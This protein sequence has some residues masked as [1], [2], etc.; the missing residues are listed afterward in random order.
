MIRT[1]A[2]RARR[3]L[4]GAALAALGTLT[5]AACGDDVEDPFVVE[6][7]GDISG[8]LYFDQGRDGFYE[9][10]EGDSALAG[11]PIV[12]RVRGTDQILASTTTDA[13]G[14]FR[15]EDIEV[16]TH[17]LVFDVD[18]D[19]AVV[20]LN[21]QPVSVRIAEVTSVAVSGQESCLIT[22][23][24][25]REAEDG[26]LVTVRGVV[27]V[28]SGDLSA[29][30]YFV[31]DATGGIKVLTNANAVLGQFVEV[32]GVRDIQFSEALIVNANLT[33]LGMGTLPDPVV[34]TGEELVSFDFQGQL[35][36]VEG[37]TVT[38]IDPASPAAGSSYNVHVAAPDGATFIVRVD[39]DA[40]IA[41]GTFVVGSTY[42]ITGVISPFG[43]A[44]Q[45]YVRSQADIEQI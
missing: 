44:E 20:C 4:R 9:P 35:A 17:D 40:G 8:L 15:F 37:L 31:Q 23:E 41:A 12:L 32:T 1:Y 13:N 45:L 3:A 36:T 11:I 14:L 2:E 26:D 43:G 5:L 28:G 7:T 34:I 22:I 6:G 19:V 24:E 30:Y 29:S 42:N 25:A 27:T 10:V 38:N 18:D 33:V 39:S 21:P 16:G